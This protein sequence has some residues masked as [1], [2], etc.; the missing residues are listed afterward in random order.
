MAIVS[1]TLTSHIPS[2]LQ[3]GNS[4]NPILLMSEDCTVPAV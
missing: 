1:L 4:S 2:D 3:C